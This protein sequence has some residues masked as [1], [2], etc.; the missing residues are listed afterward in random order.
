VEHTEDCCIQ[1]VVG[2]RFNVNCFIA[3]EL[4]NLNENG[5]NWTHRRNV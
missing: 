3:S 4:Y 1:D 2:E 5:L